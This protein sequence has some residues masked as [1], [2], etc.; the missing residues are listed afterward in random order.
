MPICA[1]E[2]ARPSRDDR[3]PALADSLTPHCSRDYR[4]RRGQEA[5]W[6]MTRIPTVCDFRRCHISSLWRLQDKSGRFSSS[7]GFR[8]ALLEY[9]FALSNR[10]RDE[11]LESIAKANKALIASSKPPT[12]VPISM[13]HRALRPATLLS[14]SRISLGSSIRLTFSFFPASPRHGS[15]RFIQRTT[16]PFPRAFHHILPSPRIPCAD[17]CTYRVRFLAGHSDV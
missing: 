17:C 13:S 3:R 6:E 12:H 11:V 10:T 9:L 7:I 15:G 14:F 16:L 8:R 5:W 4:T 1:E 2:Q